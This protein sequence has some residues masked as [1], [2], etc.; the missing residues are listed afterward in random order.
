MRL[1]NQQAIRAARYNRRDDHIGQVVNVNGPVIRVLGLDYGPEA[2]RTAK[3]V[4][5]GN[6]VLGDRVLMVQTSDEMFV[7]ASVIRNAGDDSDSLVVPGNLS[8]NTVSSNIGIFDSL[9]VNGPIVAGHV[10]AGG[11]LDVDGDVT[12]TTAGAGIEFKS[13]NGSVTTVVSI[14]N[15]GNIVPAPSSAALDAHIADTTDAHDA[16][17]I[18][19]VGG[20]GMS[21]TDVEAAIDELATEKANAADLTAHISDA[22]AAHAASA[23]SYAGG[24]GMSATDVE[25]ALDELATEKA[26]VAQEAWIAP[27]LA[28]DWSNYGGI[29]NTV[30]YYKDT[31]GRVH[32]RGLINYTGADASSTAFILPAGYRPA[33]KEVRIGHAFNGSAFALGRIDI[34][35]AGAVS[36]EVPSGSL[37]L[38]G[39]ISLDGISFRAA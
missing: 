11:G 36:K 20:T 8:A 35:A 38:N 12:L 22:T 29:F 24:T 16:S 17:A 10:E 33:F 2:Y 1:I 9:T 32:L 18:S 19:Y 28:T 3:N 13:P 27:T 31:L 34:S 39:Y 30:G 7:L 4:V 5:L 37:N 26:N 23:V 14:D 6:L 25:A 15:S 21:A